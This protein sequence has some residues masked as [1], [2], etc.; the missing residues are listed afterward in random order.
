MYPMDWE[1]FYI[2]TSTRTVDI[3]LNPIFRSNFNNFRSPTK[4]FDTTRLGAVGLYSNL[5]PFANF[6]KNNDD[7]ILLENNIKNWVEK[8]SYLLENSDE[9]RRIFENA[10]RRYEDSIR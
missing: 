2:D 3:V 9:R 7:G 10:L 1:T 6:I 8:I 5:E 4:F